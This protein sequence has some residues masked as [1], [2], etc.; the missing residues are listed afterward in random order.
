MDWDKLIEDIVIK[1]SKADWVFCD[2]GSCQGRFSTL[3]ANICKIAGNVYSFDI[4]E[5]NPFIPGCINERI[6]ISDNVTTERVYD[7]GSHMSN[8]LGTSVTGQ[9]CAFIKEIQSTTLDSYFKNKKVDCIKID[10][11]G[12]ELKVIRGGKKTIK[13]AQ[14][15]IIE[16]H[17]DDDWCE[18]YDE[19]AG[20]QMKFREISTN[21]EITRDFTKGPR[22]IRPYQI[23]Y[24]SN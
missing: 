8:I 23:Y 13:G 20:L 2:V 3:F 9:Q 7:G 1:N 21:E 12:A 18:I 10:V 24:D 17:L 19:L 11:E 15:V 16:C 6:A 5:N 22:G 4:N 14:L